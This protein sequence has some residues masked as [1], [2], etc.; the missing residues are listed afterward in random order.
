MPTFG[1]RLA[2]RR[3]CA[4]IHHGYYGYL[5]ESPVQRILRDATLLAIG[6]D[7]IEIRRAALQCHLTQRFRLPGYGDAAFRCTLQ[8]G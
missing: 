1:W 8:N 2:G 4:P 5:M 7:T 6:V 3:D